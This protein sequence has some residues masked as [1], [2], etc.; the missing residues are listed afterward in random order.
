[1]K[2]LC[3][4]GLVLLFVLTTLGAVEAAGSFW[5]RMAKGYP[6]DLVVYEYV[7]E[8]HSPEAEI[9]A[10]VPQLAG[11][12]D[13]G[14]QEHFNEVMRQAVHELTASVLEAAEQSKELESFLW[15]FPYHGHIDFELKLNQ[16]GLLSIV[17]ET[18]TFTGGAHGMVYRSYINVDLMT[19]QEISFW[20]LFD[21]EGE[22]AR[23]VDVINERIAQEPEWYFIDQFTPG[24]FAEEQGF[25]LTDSHAVICF[26]VYEIA[27]YAAG[28]Q[29][30]AV[31]AP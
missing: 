12:H 21:T 14:W 27:P 24:L 28:I 22:L 29:E 31:S 4:M 26:E 7:Y 1:M 2:K 17:L 18:Y 13:L 20:D 5:Q 15:T 23:A 11:A 30:F 25:Y 6:N 3:V 8:Y 19:G 9:T 16:G 10:R